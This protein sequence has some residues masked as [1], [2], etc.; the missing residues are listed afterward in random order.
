[1][2]SLYGKSTIFEVNITEHRVVIA[3]GPPRLSLRGMFFMTWQSDAFCRCEAF[4]AVAIPPI[5][6]NDVVE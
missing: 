6:R 1:M 3:S 5:P 4:S 2:L